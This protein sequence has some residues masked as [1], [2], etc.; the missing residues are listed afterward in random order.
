VIVDGG[1]S[2]GPVDRTSTEVTFPGGAWVSRALELQVYAG[3]V[4]EVGDCFGE[5]QR[6]EI[7]DQFDGVPAALASETV[8][9]ASVQ[10]DAER[11]GLLLVV[12]IGAEAC[13]AGPLALEGR[14]LG[15]NLDNAGCLSDLFYA[16]L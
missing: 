10:G 15:G 3:A 2:E 16:A 13:E 4:G 8:V 7:H 14:E 6:L 5:L 1:G 9:E 12:G 11:R